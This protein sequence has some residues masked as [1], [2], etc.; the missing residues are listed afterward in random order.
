MFHLR[1]LYLVIEYFVET[2][3]SGLNSFKKL[4]V[5]PE[6]HTL[7]NIH[8]R[9]TT[10]I[11]FALLD[12]QDRWT[13]EDKVQ[14][15]VHVVNLLQLSAPSGILVNFIYIKMCTTLLDKRV[16]KVNQGMIW[17]IDVVGRH[18]QVMA[19]LRQLNALKYHGGFSNTSRTN[20]TY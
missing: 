12:I 6:R 1:N 4:Q 9:P 19:C 17:K 11:N 2:E 10:Q 20:D 13:G 18:I 14:G 16:S 15:W 7:H 3:N 8:Q 5:F